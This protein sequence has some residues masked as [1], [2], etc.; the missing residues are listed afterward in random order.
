LSDFV[1][2]RILLLVAVAAEATAASQLLLQ[3]NA[4]KEQYNWKCV[5]STVNV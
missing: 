1:L 4:V 2:L 3:H 5:E